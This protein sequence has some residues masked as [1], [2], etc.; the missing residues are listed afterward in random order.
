MRAR[1]LE[2]H[3]HQPVIAQRQAK[4]DQSESANVHSQ[5]IAWAQR[6]AQERRLHDSA[7]A[8]RHAQERRLHDSAIAHL[9]QAS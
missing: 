5:D 7:W 9:R 6:H 2:A 3:R 1:Q 4:A 8:Q